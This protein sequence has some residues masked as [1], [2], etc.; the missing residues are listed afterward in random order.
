M[1]SQENTQAPAKVTVRLV[2]F[3]DG[4]LRQHARANPLL[5]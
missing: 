4:V 5:T 2:D 1:S 3:T